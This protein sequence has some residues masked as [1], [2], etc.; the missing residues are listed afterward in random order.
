[1]KGRDE[2]T[3]RC[4]VWPQERAFLCGLVDSLPE[5]ARVVNI[6]GESGCSTVALLRGGRDIADFR[7]YA[8]DILPRP[9][10]AQYARD[11]GLADPERFIQ[12]QQ[13][14]KVI[15]EGWLA[16]VHL[17]FIDGDYSYRG[18]LGDLRAWEPNV[19]A[20]GY[21][22]VH[23]YQWVY[24]TGVTRAVDEW[25][26]E[27]R[28]KGWLRIGRIDLTVIF[29]NGEPSPPFHAETPVGKYMRGET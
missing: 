7:L 27:A 16:R 25:F 19:A 18:C 9:D 3:D 5:G 6:G 14:S 10:E 12:I 13:D 2:I 8:I 1:M 22:L 21:I 26:A 24:P 11:C 15:G 23:N 17:V 28:I 20:G 4:M 29:K